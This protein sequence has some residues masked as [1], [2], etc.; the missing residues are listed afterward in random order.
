[1][2]ADLAA[3]TASG[4]AGNDILVG[5]EYVI[6]GSYN[7]TLRG[8]ASGNWLDGRDGSDDLS[9]NGGNDALLGGAGNDYLSGGAGVD[10]LIG[11]AGADTF[12]LRPGD[13]G[14]TL[15]LADV[16]TDYQDGTDSIGLGGG[17]TFA[18]LTITQNASD[19]VIQR[20]S[21]GEYLAV[22]QNVSAASLDAL[23]FKPVA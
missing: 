18:G 13:G 12:V 14:A 4:G 16:I 15:N 20:T 11:G 9:G 21:T 1:V 8:D 6:G 2:T 19:A 10:N 17:L 7:D 23:D 22:L 3:G 5:I